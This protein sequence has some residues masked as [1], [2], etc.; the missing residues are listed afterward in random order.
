MELRLKRI[1]RRETYTIGHLYV[2]GEYFCDTCE[3]KD[4]GLRQDMDAAKI[5]MIA[6]GVSVASNTVLNYLLIFGIGGIPAMG[7]AGAA[8]ATVMNGRPIL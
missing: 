4:R 3:D 7:V 5:P 2:D 8:V 1:A 6:G